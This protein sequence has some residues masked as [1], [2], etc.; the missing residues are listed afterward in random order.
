MRTLNFGRWKNQAAGEPQTTF[1]ECILHLVVA[2]HVA[3]DV[4]GGS[5]G[6]AF[7]HGGRYALG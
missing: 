5:H 2:I 4:V 1:L 7:S 3:V 6:E